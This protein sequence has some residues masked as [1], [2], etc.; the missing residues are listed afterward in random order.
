LPFLASTRLGLSSSAIGVVVMIN[1][2]VAGLFQAP[3]GFLADRF[4]KRLLVAAGGVLGVFSI[5]YLNT[6]VSFGGLLF[7]NALLGV[8]GGVSFPAIMALGVI[9]GRSAGGMGSIMGLLAMAHSLGMLLGP[10]LAGVLIDLISLGSIFVFGA[11]VMTT[12][13]VIFLIAR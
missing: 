12:G 6:A 4:S 10:L 9:E 8:A 13:T 11:I 7:G 3:M 5:L 2:L 1:V